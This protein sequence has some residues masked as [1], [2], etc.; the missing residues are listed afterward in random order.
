MKG[1]IS[2]ET[3]MVF[4]IGIAVLSLILTQV[5]SIKL[6]GENFIERKNLKMI[7]STIKSLCKTTLITNSKQEISMTITKQ[8]NINVKNNYCYETT[9]FL[10]KGLNKLIFKPNYNKVTV[11][12][13]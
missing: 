10:K 5:Q 9:L 11:T 1:Q 3:I 8:A 7:N 2:L 4:A 12:S 6:T 13:I